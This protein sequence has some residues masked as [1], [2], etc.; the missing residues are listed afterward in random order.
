MSLTYRYSCVDIG[1]GS[2][3]G[4][5][6]LVATVG[7]LSL[8]RMGKRTNRMSKAPRTLLTP[9]FTS[10]SSSLMNRPPRL[11]RLSSLL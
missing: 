3:N 1:I 11:T 7:S 2:L 6:S 4:A 8:T 9:I 5:I 10:K